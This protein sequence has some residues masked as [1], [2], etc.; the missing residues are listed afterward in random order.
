[1]F[2]VALQGSK[3]S[4]IDRGQYAVTKFSARNVVRGRSPTFAAL[5]NAPITLC[6]R[7]KISGS[8]HP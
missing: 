3:G 1:L 8:S 7:V 5:L 4:R 6:D 2:G